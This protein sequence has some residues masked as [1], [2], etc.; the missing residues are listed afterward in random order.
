MYPTLAKPVP[1]SIH[2]YTFFPSRRESWVHDEAYRTQCS[3][4]GVTDARAD[5]QDAT[6]PSP[7]PAA[8]LELLRGSVVRSGG[9]VHLMVAP[10]DPTCRSA[11]LLCRRSPEFVIP[12]RGY[13]RD[14]GDSVWN[15]ADTN[16]VAI[17]A[18]DNKRSGR[19]NDYDHR[20]S[21]SRGRKGKGEAEGAGRA[22]GK[23]ERE[24][25]GARGD[26]LAEAEHFGVE[27]TRHLGENDGRPGEGSSSACFLKGATGI[28]G[29][30]WVERLHN[31]GVIT[32]CS[33][34]VIPH[35]ALDVRY[36]DLEATEDLSG[37]HLIPVPVIVV[38][39]G[40]GIVFPV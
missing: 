38:A 1:F 11:R 10:T 14:H 28:D 34:V 4:N 30:G 22:A 2:F 39:G 13:Y 36:H 35:E 8:A 20:S 6:S 3:L 19:R 32:A 12:T 26:D 25:A 21:G 33:E 37:A 24:Y 17:G 18:E 5:S 40:G 16:G 9:V 15:D 7:R 23:G 27:K 31:W 29:R